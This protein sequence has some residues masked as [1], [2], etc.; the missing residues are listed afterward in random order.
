MPA[1]IPEFLVFIKAKL[2]DFFAGKMN[3][4]FDFAVVVV[5]A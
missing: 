5:E 4:Y 3:F 2:K 1:L